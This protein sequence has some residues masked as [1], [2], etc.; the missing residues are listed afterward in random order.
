[1]SNRREW[2]P[3]ATTADRLK[4]VMAASGYLSRKETAIMLGTTRANI[5]DFASHHGIRFGDVAPIRIAARMTDDDDTTAMAGV[6][7]LD[8]EIARLGL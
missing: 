7:P 3:S 1:M 4:Q 8:R 5:T 6:V 2:W